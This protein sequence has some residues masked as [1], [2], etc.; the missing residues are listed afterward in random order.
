MSRFAIAGSIFSE[1]PDGFQFAEKRLPL[2]VMKTIYAPI[3]LRLI[4][5][6]SVRVCTFILT[7]IMI[8]NISIDVCYYYYC[9]HL[10]HLR[11]LLK[12]RRVID[13]ILS[14]LEMLQHLHDRYLVRW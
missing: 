2:N 13:T 7:L 5:R 8:I 11:M 1:R 14:T 3:M 6:N 12:W 9:Y 10:E 4:P